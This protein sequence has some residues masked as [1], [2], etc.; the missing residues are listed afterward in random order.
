[1]KRLTIFAPLA[2]CVFCMVLVA[3]T[4]A[5][6]TNYQEKFDSSMPTV[7]E[8]ARV[9]DVR[10]NPTSAY[11]PEINIILADTGVRY[12]CYPVYDA[13]TAAPAA[14][15]TPN[16]HPVFQTATALASI[17]PTATTIPLITATPYP[18][19][20]PHIPSTPTQEFA[21]SPTPALIL[22]V[23][24]APNGLNVRSAAGTNNPVV[25][26]LG[27]GSQVQVTGDTQIVG[28]VTWWELTSGGWVSGAWLE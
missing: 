5:S 15:W 18:T 16:G 10:F 2:L 28:I 3:C 25:G 21:G 9:A 17:S 13:P 27:Y 22:K 4:L 19:N 20:T 23:V 11:Q 26:S 1:M 12:V 7:A 6:E 14:T 24:T 8:K